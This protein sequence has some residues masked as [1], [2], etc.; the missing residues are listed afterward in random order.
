MSTH[1]FISIISAGLMLAVTVVSGRRGTST[2]AYRAAVLGYGLAAAH[3]AVIVWAAVSG[4]AP[5]MVV[6]NSGI[7]VPM[8]VSIAALASHTGRNRAAACL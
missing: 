3:Y 6:V 2:W 8:F 5:V 7:G 4:L 1:A